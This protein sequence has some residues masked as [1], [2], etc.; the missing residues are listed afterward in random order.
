M[1][2]SS[3]Q[4]AALAFDVSD[5]KASE[6]DKELAQMEA[7]E[8]A[9][10]SKSKGKA[11]VGTTKKAPTKL[12]KA[13]VDFAKGGFQMPGQPK[14]PAKAAADT[15]DLAGKL[16]KIGII[17]SYHEHPRWK[18]DYGPFKALNPLK[19]THEELDAKITHCKSIRNRAFAPHAAVKILEAI[20]YGI[21]FGYQNYI[22][23]QPWNPLKGQSLAGLGMDIS[24]N[25]Q[26]FQDELDEMVILYP[27]F[28]QQPL[29]MRFAA[30]IYLVSQGT[31]KKNHGAPTA[32]SAPNPDYAGLFN[33]L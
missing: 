4:H 11:K 23:T 21:E 12:N 7:D 3:A 18:D 16:Q 30:K 13:Q 15:T 20:G 26:L 6:I 32:D 2:G 8:K 22:F 17:K 9:A 19:I 28:F 31:S 1:A 33:D 25:S 29:W 24:R 5:L 10:K 14:T 27:G